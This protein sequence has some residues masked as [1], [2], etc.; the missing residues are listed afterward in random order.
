M[1]LN[2]NMTETDRHNTSRHQ[3]A[4]APTLS[5]AVP[6]SLVSHFFYFPRDKWKMS[7]SEK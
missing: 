6:H 5:V 3:P 2:E 1:D 4:L 7:L